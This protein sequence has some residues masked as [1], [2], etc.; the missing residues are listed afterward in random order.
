MVSFAEEHNQIFYQ[1][2]DNY[3]KYIVPYIDFIC[4]FLCLRYQMFYSKSENLPNKRR[5][6]NINECTPSPELLC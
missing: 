4:L 6:L 2:R 1:M 3:R 5:L